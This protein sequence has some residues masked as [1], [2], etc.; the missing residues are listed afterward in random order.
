MSLVVRSSLCFGRKFNHHFS[1]FS[2]N[3]AAPQHQ[4]PSLP[5]DPRRN[6]LVVISPR[7]GLLLL[8]PN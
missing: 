2:R 6:Y 3:H 1:A 4:P 8:V 5:E 7:P